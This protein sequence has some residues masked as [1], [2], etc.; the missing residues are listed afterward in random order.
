MFSC[1]QSCP[2][3][4]PSRHNRWFCGSLPHARHA[5][6]GW[7]IL[8]DNSSVMRTLDAFV[9]S[10][11]FNLLRSH[12]WKPAPSSRPYARILLHQHWP[13]RYHRSTHNMLPPTMSTHSMHVGTTHHRAT[14]KPPIHN[15]HLRTLCPYAC[16]RRNRCRHCRAPE[17]SPTCTKCRRRHP[18]CPHKRSIALGRRYRHLPHRPHVESRRHRFVSREPLTRSCALP[19]TPMSADAFVA[20]ALSLPCWCVVT[21]TCRRH[22]CARMLRLNTVTATQDA[23]VRNPSTKRARSNS[24]Q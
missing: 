22:F 3:V 20:T 23:R 2:R 1:D 17:S 9:C 10:P 21:R 18:I 8:Q 13:T 24:T 16:P 4:I 5:Y 6:R 15:R 19:L 14:A 7:P 11:R 12:H